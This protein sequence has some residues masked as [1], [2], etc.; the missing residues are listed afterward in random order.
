MPE[1]ATKNIKC[2]KLSGGRFTPSETSVI[3]E[4]ELPVY[5][6]G[7]HLFTASITPGMEK[8]FVAG[9]LFGQ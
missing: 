2:R 5:V 9:Y 6:N 8:E 7:A 1:R 3:V 4:K